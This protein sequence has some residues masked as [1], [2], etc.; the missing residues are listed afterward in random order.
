MIFFF[1]LFLHFLSLPSSSFSLSFSL[2]LFPSLSPFLSLEGTNEKSTEPLELVPAAGRTG[3]C[4]SITRGTKAS[5]WHDKTLPRRWDAMGKAAGMWSL[6]RKD[7]GPELKA[8]RQG[9]YPGNK[10]STFWSLLGRKLVH[11]WAFG[12]EPLPLHSCLPPLPTLSCRGWSL[13]E[14]F[15]FYKEGSSKTGLLTDLLMP[16]IQPV[17]KSCLLCMVGFQY[18]EPQSWHCFERVN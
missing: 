9:W 6:W 16:G 10:C 13:F 8:A 18:L 1:L 11:H 3:R 5:C 14:Y 15:S 4:Q 2:I 17:L 7:V 12:L